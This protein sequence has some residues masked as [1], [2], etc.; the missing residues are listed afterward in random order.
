MDSRMTREEAN[1]F[2]QSV[3]EAVELMKAFQ[4]TMMQARDTLP[5]SYSQIAL[6]HTK[7]LDA[8]TERFDKFEESFTPVFKAY[9]EGA[10]FKNVFFALLKGIG[11][12]GAAYVVVKM[13]WHD[14]FPAK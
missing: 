5:P 3:Q 2:K 8:L 10:S 13:A 12:F 11:V 14:L 9:E 1:E 6:D 4:R 7:K